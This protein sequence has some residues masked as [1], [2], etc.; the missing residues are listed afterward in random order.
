MLCR[1]PQGL[2]EVFGGERARGIDKPLE[3][4]AGEKHMVECADRPRSVVAD[5]ALFLIKKERSQPGACCVQVAR[6]KLAGLRLAHHLRENLEVG[7]P[8]WTVGFEGGDDSRPG[9]FEPLRGRDIG[10]NSGPQ[11]L[12][13]ILIPLTKR[14]QKGFRKERIF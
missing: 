10:R 1:T 5:G 4:H 14:E 2:S 7:D 6:E 13:E 8:E 11:R 3:D 9:G 12:L